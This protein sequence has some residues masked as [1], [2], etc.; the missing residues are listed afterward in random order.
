MIEYYDRDGRPMTS[1]EWMNDFE[2]QN[3]KRVAFDTIN[4]FDISTVWLG[5]NHQFGD[6]PPMIF[7]TMV[8]GGPLDQE[9]ERYSTEE[10]AISGH[11]AMCERV[12]VGQ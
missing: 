12:K 4:G 5:L 10:E 1:A 3:K 6:G 2:R 7:E 8:F 9:C 11:A